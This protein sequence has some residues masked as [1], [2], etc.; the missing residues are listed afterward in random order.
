MALGNGSDVTGESRADTNAEVKE[1]GMELA[2]SVLL[3]ES[4][5]VLVLPINPSN[6]ENMGVAMNVELAMTIG[7][8]RAD[9]DVLV[10]LLT[11]TLTIITIC[12]LIRG[13]R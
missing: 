11:I 7:A 12:S 4:E 9:L 13:L 5:S 3:C 10:V 8:I 1:V 6:N 2:E